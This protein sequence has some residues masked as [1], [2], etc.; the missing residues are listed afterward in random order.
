MKTASV[1]I[2]QIIAKTH[3]VHLQTAIYE[4][5]RNAVTLLP[6]NVVTGDYEPRRDSNSNTARYSS[7]AYYLWKVD[8]KV[9]KHLKI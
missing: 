9:N 7:L 6:C 1:I 4:R 2:A 3:P 5:T 8:L